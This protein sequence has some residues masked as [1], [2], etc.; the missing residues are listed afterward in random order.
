M[1]MSERLIGTWK[2]ISVKARDIDTG[3]ERDAWGPNPKGYINYGPDGRVMVINA[4]SGRTKP[5]GPAPT[6]QE[7]ADLFQGMLAY[8][9]SY[10]VNGDT[11]THHVDVSWNETWTG[12]DMV[13]IA[14]FDGDRVHLST[15]PTPDPVN[16]RI[17][18]RTM[19]WERFKPGA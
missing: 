15:R 19:T 5:K 14:R 8:A 2:L 11:V 1:G 12:A 10:S 16:G 3:E 13:R 9:G 6:P 4:R 7:A 17:S 18:V